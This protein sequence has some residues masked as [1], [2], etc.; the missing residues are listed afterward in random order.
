[1]RKHVSG[2][3]A[4]WGP[5]SDSGISLTWIIGRE[6]IGLRKVRRHTETLI[7]K[8]ATL[9]FQLSSTN[10]LLVG[11]NYPPAWDYTAGGWFRRIGFKPG[12]VEPRGQ[13]GGLCGH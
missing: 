1:M 4:C 12:D 2:A 6:S 10:L 11:K 9:R 13:G 3:R 5:I 8:T 7:L